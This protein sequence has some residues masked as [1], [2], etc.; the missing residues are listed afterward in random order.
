MEIHRIIATFSRKVL[1]S[2]ISYY[3][4][5]KIPLMIHEFVEKI[6]SKNERC[7]QFS[8]QM[9]TDVVFQFE[10]VEIE[11]KKIN[12]W[13]EL[14]YLLVK[15][16]WSGT[17]LTSILLCIVPFNATFIVP[18]VTAVTYVYVCNKMGKVGESVYINKTIEIDIYV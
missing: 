9:Y 13:C 11:N 12:K 2:L 16:Y 15:F 4:E 17:L 18:L 8:Y 7:W 14:W 1:L 5:N 6:S 10:F 3:N